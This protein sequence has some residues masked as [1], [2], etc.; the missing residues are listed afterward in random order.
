MYNIT[1]LDRS[2]TSVLVAR[3]LLDLQE[4]NRQQVYATTSAAGHAKPCFSSYTTTTQDE[5]T[6]VFAEG[7]MASLDATIMFG[8]SK[9]PDFDTE[10]D[11]VEMGALKGKDV[12]KGDDS[13]E[14]ESGNTS[15]TDSGPP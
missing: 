8:L 13:D 4:A 12:M 14:P 10:R 15:P 5:E 11:G 6:M 2:V 9:D 3:L 7:F 1:Y